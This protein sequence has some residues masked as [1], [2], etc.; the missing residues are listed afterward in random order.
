M[1]NTSLDETLNQLAQQMLSTRAQS[2]Q[3]LAQ[4][5]ALTEQMKALERKALHDPAARQKLAQIKQQMA[6][7]L[8]SETE[9]EK[10]MEVLL[11]AGD[12]MVQ[13]INL[14]SRSP[15]AKTI[16]DI[17]DAQP[18]APTSKPIKNHRFI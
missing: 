8:P 2:Q 18:A 4:H 12:K 16:Y 14:V 7:K 1:M 11:K 13:M 3:L 9:V 5:E 6:E 10:V 17:I 15:K